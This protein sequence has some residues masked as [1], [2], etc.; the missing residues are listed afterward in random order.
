ME[1]INKRSKIKLCVK[2]VKS[3]E[4]LKIFNFAFPKKCSLTSLNECRYVTHATVVVQLL[5]WRS[6]KCY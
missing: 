2:S 3:E 5:N 6:D 4:I 1:Q